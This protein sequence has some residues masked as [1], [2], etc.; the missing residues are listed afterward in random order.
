MTIVLSLG[1]NLGNRLDNLHSAVSALKKILTNVKTSF[2]YENEAL[3]PS[4]APLSWNIP[5]YNMIIT[6]DTKLDPL[7]LLGAVKRIER[8]L[9]RTPSDRWAPRIIDIDIIFYDQLILNK[10]ELIIPHKEACNRPFVMIPLYQIAPSFKHPVLHSTI[11]QIIGNFKQYVGTFKRAIP[12]EPKIMGIL[13]VTKNSFS[14]G[15]KFFH[16]DQAVNQALKILD[17]GA[18]I[19]DIGAQSTNVGVHHA[20]KFTEKQKIKPELSW[21]EELENLIPILDAITKELSRQGKKLKISIDSFY[22]EVF[23]HLLD[24]YPISIINDV[25]GA[26]NDKMIDIA[27]ATGIKYVLMHSIEIP[28][29]INKLIPFDI[30]PVTQLMSWAQEKITLLTNKGVSQ[31]KIIFDPGIGFDKSPSQCL[32]IMKNLS[33]FKELGLQTL[34][35]HSRKFF[36]NSFLMLPPG[37]RDLETAVISAQMAGKADYIR[38]HNV[39]ATMRAIVAHNAVNATADPSNK[40]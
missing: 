32:Y 27:A 34:L 9:G 40:G 14:D 18:Y 30:D 11:E 7:A 29:R 24:K 22:P 36:M 3:L 28:T 19:L 25:S 1:T 10:E 21:Q 6:G 2:I 38:V 16:V 5:Y 12:F 37:E 15:G 17:E 13:N 39:E 20:S 8:D 35:G 23:K 33:M 31:D 4:G 26:S